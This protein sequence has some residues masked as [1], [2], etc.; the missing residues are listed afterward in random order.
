M[1][2][3]SDLLDSILTDPLAQA[4]AAGSAVGYVGFDIPEDL[5]AASGRHIC[6]LPWQADR[7]TP[8]ADG[9]LESSFPGWSR[10]ILEDWADGRFDFFEAVIFSRGDDSA[11]R[12]YYYVCELQRR[13]LI[14]GPE[15]LIF[16]IARIGRDT[17]IKRSVDAVRRLAGRLAISDA[18][19]AEGIDVANRR[20]AIFDKVESGRTSNGAL[21]ERISRASLFASLDNEME[22]FAAPVASLSGRILLAGTAPPDDSLHRTVDELGWTVTGDAHDRSLTRLGPLLAAGDDPAASIGAQAHD[23]V[24]GAR[25]FANRADWLVTEARRARADAVVL[26][27]VEQEEALVWHVPAQ[28]RALDAAGIPALVM[29]RRRWDG[30]DGAASEIAEFI[31]GLR[32]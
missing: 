28:K 11:Q 9:W 23:L 4:R 13:G 19:L 20:R 26:W 7:A 12:L 2:A 25:S 21:Y 5:L 22:G 24:I 31:G 16:D 30:N 27:L 8:K 1:T 18:M 6:H 32:A 15:A 14:G 10:S 29:T 3:L 17:S